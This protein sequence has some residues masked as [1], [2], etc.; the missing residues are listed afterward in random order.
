MARM[1]RLAIVLAVLALVGAA[2]GE[3]GTGAP[4]VPA[5]GATIQP[6][7]APGGGVVWEWSKVDLDP[8]V[9]GRCA[10]LWNGVWSGSQWVALGFVAPDSFAGTCEE[11]ERMFA[12][13]KVGKTAAWTSPDG[14]VWERVGMWDAWMPM[15][16]TVGGPGLVA[17]GVSWDEAT[18][19]ARLSPVVWLSTNGE[20][21]WPVEDPDLGVSSGWIFGVAAAADGL[22]AV[23]YDC[24]DPQN[25]D[26]WDGWGFWSGRSA[27]WTS[28]DGTEWVRVPH[29]ATVFPDHSRIQGVA[30]THLGWIAVGR[31]TTTPP[32]GRFVP[33]GIPIAWISPDGIAWTSLDLPTQPED[34]CPLESPRGVAAV[35][36]H[37]VITGKCD[38]LN[39]FQIPVVWTSDT[40]TE[41]TIDRFADHHWGSGSSGVMTV[42]DF[43]FLIAG[44]RDDLTVWTS[45]DGTTWSNKSLGLPMWIGD[46][47]AHGGTVL[48]IGR[49]DYPTA[50]NQARV[51]VGTAIP[52]N[53]TEN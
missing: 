12:G 43:G 35:G 48:V 44:G 42:T 40:G 9:T 27:V 31:H 15:A 39:Q 11:V 5:A 49:S 30:A 26:C 8:A 36:Q 20:D 37:V 7:P 50:S 19:P 45:P 3:D 38:T 23:G 13:P 22:V 18:E 34:N 21:W 33:P 25:V 6:T 28:A 1:G 24:A 29:D 10:S 47:S 52:T 4:V 2:C 41:W 17:V 16:I 46:A 32:E 51:W 53:T 14:I